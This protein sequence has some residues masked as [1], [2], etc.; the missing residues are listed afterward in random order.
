MEYKVLDELISMIAA[1]QA[2]S[3]YDS[4]QYNNE[5]LI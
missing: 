4:T 3:S 2:K 5:T 1:K